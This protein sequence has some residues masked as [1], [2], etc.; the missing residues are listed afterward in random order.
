MG[1]ISTI[2]G[3]SYAII[4]A[5]NAGAIA[6]IIFCVLMMN[7]GADE[8]HQMKRR[9]RNIIIFMIVADTIFTLKQIANYYYG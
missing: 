2:D 8:A 1:S 7:S 5:I 3:L 6:R 9:I 4:G